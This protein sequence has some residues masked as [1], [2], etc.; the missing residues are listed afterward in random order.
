MVSSF[1]CNIYFYSMNYSDSYYYAT[2]YVSNVV[3]DEVFEKLPQ[4]GYCFSVKS[5]A[6]F[7]DGNM[8]FVSFTSKTVKDFGFS[9]GRYFASPEKNS[10]ISLSDTL[11]DKYVIV[12]DDEIFKDKTEYVVDNVTYP[13]KAK[14]KFDYSSY[15]IK[16]VAAEG[17]DSISFAFIIDN[18]VLY[19]QGNIVE[20][21]IINPESSEDSL[22]LITTFNNSYT[23]QKVF[24]LGSEMN[25]SANVS[26]SLYSVM[27]LIG[28]LVP[29]FFIVILF[30]MVIRMIN[31][32]EANELSLLRMFG[33]S[34]GKVWTNL[35]LF[36]LL[37]SLPGFAGFC[38]IFIP[39][40][41]NLYPSIWLLA[42]LTALVSF[43]YLVF[44]IAV[45]SAHDASKV[46]KANY[47][48]KG[49]TDD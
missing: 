49:E 42:V 35:F 5:K 34:K 41:L 33:F 24:T 26:F 37:F 25:H 15:F 43:L 48:Y 30:S 29:F 18:D 19:N 31:S 13:I 39:I 45:L 11:E 3:T 44:S 27:I 38:L 2:N 20:S 23:N 8:T 40:F 7:Q 47:L 46:F 16:T 4:D 1:F 10:Y 22:D 28:F 17:V 9:F 14:M 6:D 12:S 21:L 32:F 36:R